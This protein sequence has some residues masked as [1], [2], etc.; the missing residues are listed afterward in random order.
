MMARTQLDEAVGA[1]ASVTITELKGRMREIVGFV[2][3]HGPV[4]ILR[5]KT[6]DAVLIS[7]SDY[8]EFMKLKRERL[9]FLT[10]RYD[11]MVDRMQAPEAIAG[12]DSL[13]S[14][15]SADLGRAAVAATRRG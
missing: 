9:N 12:V 7:A 3:Q 15:T 13:F 5:H 6:T 11:E 8:V 2:A 4:A 14:A 1:I 10:Q